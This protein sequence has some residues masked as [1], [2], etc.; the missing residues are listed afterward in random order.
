MRGQKE[1][2]YGACAN[3]RERKRRGRGQAGGYGWR[4]SGN[5]KIVR[6]ARVSAPPGCLMCVRQSPPPHPLPTPPPTPPPITI[7]CTVLFYHP[8]NA[9]RMTT[10][11]EKATAQRAPLRGCAARQ[12]SAFTPAAAPP[13]S[14]TTAGAEQVKTPRQKLKEVRQGV[15]GGTPHT[16]LQ[17]PH[18]L[19]CLSPRCL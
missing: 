18:R 5:G 11:A 4:A 2:R 16:W 14:A 19:C 13:H 9:Q 15:G 8:I 12:E 1:H 17:Q 10:N 7:D 6:P 3:G